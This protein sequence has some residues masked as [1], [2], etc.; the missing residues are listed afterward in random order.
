MNTTSRLALFIAAALCSSVCYADAR[1]AVI[2]PSGE[3]SLTAAAAKLA[4][5]V[6]IKTR[7]VQ[8]GKPSDPRPEIIESNCTYSRYPCSVVDRIEISVNGNRIFVPRSVY[9][10]LADLNNGEIQLRKAGAV[11]RLG[12]GDGSEGYIVT[13]EFDTDR[14]KRRIVA[15]G[16]SPKSVMEETKYNGVV[17]GD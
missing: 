12:G 6:K 9:S 5:Q 3:T 2:S 17:M 16:M 1:S 15:P 13:I 7:E 8:I 10:D 11:L 4:L 14:V